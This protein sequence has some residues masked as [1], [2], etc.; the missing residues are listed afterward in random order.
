M[1]I[2]L[3]ADNH[4]RVER[5]E[6]ILASETYDLAIHLGDGEVSQ[7]YLAKNFDHYVCG[8]HEYWEPL[9]KVID[10][11]GIPTLL[12]HGHTHPMA[13]LIENKMQKLFKK[14]QVKL[15]IHGHLHIFIHHT[16]EDNH[17]ICPGSTDFPRGME[18]SGYVILTTEN[19][20]VKNVEFKNN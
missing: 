11:D 16:Y 7:D 17:V 12:L 18:G 1:K 4:G 19:G 9:E 20:K 3:V 6:K 15:I 13:L 5:L 8:N 2:L 10:L 14:Y